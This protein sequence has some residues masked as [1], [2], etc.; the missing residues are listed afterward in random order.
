MKFFRFSLVQ[1]FVEWVVIANYGIILSPESW[2]LCFVLVL[3]VF[4]E[5]FI[6]NS[7][8]LC[9]V[10]LKYNCDSFSGILLE[11]QNEEEE[12]EDEEE[13]FLT[14]ASSPEPSTEPVFLFPPGGS[15]STAP[16]APPPERKVS[17]LDSLPEATRLDSCETLLYRKMY[18][19]FTVQFN[20]MQIIVA[21]VRAGE[22]LYRL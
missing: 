6:F 19:R 20:N 14:P 8:I 13:E 3:L 5:L 21:K 7:T 15:S 4:V 1:Q 12:E 22:N 11:Q 18:D 16:G 9:Y 2:V 17:R 10:D